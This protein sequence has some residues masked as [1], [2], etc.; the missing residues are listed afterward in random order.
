MLFFLG[1]A[2]AFQP[3]SSSSSSSSASKW[4]CRGGAAEDD[5]IVIL[6]TSPIEG[7][8]PGTSG[9]RKK[10]RVWVEDPTYTLNF[11][12]SLMDG[13]CVP[14]GVR[15]LVIGG[16]GREYSGECFEILASVAAANG[17]HR[18]VAPKGGVISTPAASALVRRLGVDGA[19]LMTASHNPGGLD[20]DFGIKFNDRDGS[21]AREDLTEAV[22]AASKTL[23]RIYIKRTNPLI[24]N[25]VEMVD[26]NDAYVAVL[27]E[28]FDF[29]FLREKL[30]RAS[31]VFDAMH[32]A[33][34]PAA[35]RVLA[36]ELQGDP[37]CLLRCDPR[38]DFGGGH[39]DPNLKWAADLASRFGLDS[40]GSSTSNF[41]DIFPVIGCACDGDGD[42]NMIVGAGIFVTPSDSLAVLAARAHKIRWFGRKL[43]AVARSM[44]T[45]RAV[46]R[47]AAHL[48]IPC[49]ETPTGW[50][51]FGNLM[52]RYSPFLCGEESFGTG[53]DHV[54]EK[55]GL[56][57]FLAWLS[58]LDDG[59]TVKDVMHSHWRQF[60]RDLYARYDF[61][62]VDAA[63]AAEMFDFL[64]SRDGVEEFDYT[65]PVDGSRATR[66]GIIL[67][68][69]D[70]N[71]RAVFRL[72]G[73]GS[74]GATVRLYLER[75]VPN[76]AQKDL[77]AVPAIVLADLARTAM[78]F[79]RLP[80][81][82]GKSDPDVVT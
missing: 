22:Y 15:S 47:V 13:W 74:A 40:T 28:C 20:G 32:G 49:L 29:E 34:G 31:F 10:T 11:A 43:A 76:P 16:D 48:G 66:Q 39:P 41:E 44:P 77:D 57:A 71:E 45:S 78:S 8:R 36:D 81:F 25:N 64:R 38:P 72:S 68:F 2:L 26:A 73:T 69:P 33:A 21:P 46:D 42:R 80:D 50:K 52:E 67:D 51:Y 58:I 54:R 12:Q 6:E 59:E 5:S 3:R 24:N 75:Y 53:A 14:K 55:D 35:R 63:S 19:V 7:M 1:A 56:W 79:A 23:K 70:T 61:E 60:G 65:D 4:W 82:L 18:I 30:R 27:R 17:V 37:S 9:L 62:E